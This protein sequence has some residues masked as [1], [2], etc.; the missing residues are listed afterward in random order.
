MLPI[1]SAELAQIQSDL[2]SAACNLACTVQRKTRTPDGA[3]TSSETWTTISPN[4]LKAG[5]SQPTE[6]LLTNYGYRIESMN[7]WLVKLPWGTTMTDGSGVKA[8]DRL[9]ITQGTITYTL[10]AHVGLDPRS[11]PGLEIWLA[12]VLKP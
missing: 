4:G 8:Q 5:M 7:T 2:A 3:G 11:Y 12:A 6:Q 10:E 1:S 9:L